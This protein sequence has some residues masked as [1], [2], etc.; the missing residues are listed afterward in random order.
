[1]K[2]IRYEDGLKDAM[3]LINNYIKAYDGYIA[4]DFIQI[5]NTTFNKM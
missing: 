5:F 1:M 2:I 4:E 3:L